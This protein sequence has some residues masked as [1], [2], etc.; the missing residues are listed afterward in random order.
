MRSSDRG[1]IHHI[2]DNHRNWVRLHN[3][4]L[5]L[6]LSY[7]WELGKDQIVE[8]DSGLNDHFALHWCIM[9]SELFQNRIKPCSIYVVHSSFIKFSRMKLLYCFIRAPWPTS[10]L[11]LSNFLKQPYQDRKFTWQSI[12]W[13]VYNKS[14]YRKF[15]SV[16]Q[17][18]FVLV[19]I[20]KNVLVS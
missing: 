5:V 3:I 2:K 13:G 14:S 15:S 10:R 4:T 8:Q 7:V 19:I 17:V 16:E 9:I 1:F 11:I 18:Y 12:F 6:W 20:I